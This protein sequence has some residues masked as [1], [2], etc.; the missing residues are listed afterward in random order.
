MVQEQ[1]L[2]C[3]IGAGH[4]SGKKGVLKLLKDKGYKVKPVKL[5]GKIA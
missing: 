4:L 2:F 3:A 5:K 1:T